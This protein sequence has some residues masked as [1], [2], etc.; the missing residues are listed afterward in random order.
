LTNQKKPQNTNV[1]LQDRM[2]NA[3]KEQRIKAKVFLTNGFQMDGIIKDFDN[4]TILLV[5]DGK[6][7]MIYKHAISTIEP[8]KNIF[9]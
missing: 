3:L 9:Y 7:K 8:S 6:E 2:Y 4:F 1:S 5:K